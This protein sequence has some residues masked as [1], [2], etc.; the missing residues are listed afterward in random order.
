MSFELYETSMG[1]ERQA[2]VGLRKDS[3]I[4]FNKMAARHLANYERVQ[5]YY[6][7]SRQLIAIKPV[8]EDA[9][10]SMKIRRYQ[11]RRSTLETI[12]T[13]KGFFDFYDLP[14][15]SC[16]RRVRY[17]NGMLIVS[18][19]EKPKNADPLRVFHGEKAS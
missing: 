8:N 2:M 19:E 4:T 17:E 7:R 3:A 6:D 15:G 9:P 14:R 10:N 11:K 13:C 18:L 5:L 1:G 12:V 16:K